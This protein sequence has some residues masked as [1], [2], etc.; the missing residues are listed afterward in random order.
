MLGVTHSKLA[1]G[2]ENEHGRNAP[3]GS[4]KASAQVDRA[5][6]MPGRPLD[7]TT[8]G[9][10]ETSFGYDFSNVRIHDDADAAVTAAGVNAAAFTFGQDV[11]F[12]AGRYAPSTG[13]GRELL[14]HELAHTIQQRDA[15]TEGTDV[16][17]GSTLEQ[18]AAQAGRA[19]ALGAPVTHS[20]GSSSLAVARQ[21]AEDDLDWVPDE[22]T[23]DER[24]E[25]L[26]YQDYNRS[27]PNSKSKIADERFAQ[28]VGYARRR[29][30]S[31][32]ASRAAAEARSGQVEIPS[33]TDEDDEAEIAPTPMALPEPPAGKRPT[34]PPPARVR[35]RRRGEPAAQARF[36]PGGFTDEEAE[37]VDQESREALWHAEQEQKRAEAE[38][39]RE[40]DESGPDPIVDGYVQT[41]MGT[42]EHVRMR[43]SELQA[44]QDR[45]W[46]RPILEQ[47]NNIANAGPV[48]TAG[49]VVGGTARVLRGGESRDAVP[50]A[51]ALGGVGDAF[52]LGVGA[53]P[54]QGTA[55]D[56]GRAPGAIVG[57]APLRESIPEPQ[58]LGQTSTAPE[59]AATTVETAPASVAGQT[60]PSTASTPDPAP[61]SV[62]GQTRPSTASTPDPAPA[63]VA[64]QTRPSTAST[65]DPAPA[66]VAGQTRPS[67]APTPDPAP[68]A[69]QP[70][71]PRVVAATRQLAN[72]QNAA[73]SASG[74][75]QRA[76][77]KAAEAEHAHQ[78][79]EMELAKARTDVSAAQV[80]RDSASEAYRNAKPGSRQEPRKAFTQAKN[81][82]EKLE[83]KLNQAERKVTTA[84]EALNDATAAVKRQ[85]T[86]SA[87]LKMKAERAQ[88]RLAAT[89]RA[90]A[91]GTP[92][93]LKPGDAFSPSKRRPNFIP[94]GP[95]G[96]VTRGAAGELEH[97][98]EV[99]V[100]KDPFK[101][102]AQQADLQRILKL[103]KTNPQQAGNEFAKLT[104]QI[105]R[106]GDIAESYRAVH[107]TIGRR[108]DFGNIKELTIE[109]R[110]GALGDSKL[111]QLWFDLN[112]HG[113]IDLTVPMLSSAAEDQ[114]ARLAGEWQK[115]T[116]RKPLILVRETAR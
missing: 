29:L 24:E 41:D 60:R 65:P 58:Q 104:G 89:E 94:N 85:A 39:A 16:G 73:D 68:A 64:G 15:S 44:A 106:W 91:Q 108:W 25:F 96:S 5:L 100:F 95:R 35:P 49:L 13:E 6:T 69:P 8:R 116:G 2:E 71:D 28:L 50:S 54:L 53:P 88:A 79:A 103:A 55:A 27:F 67:T 7:P 63:P 90:V 47:M 4:G 57:E 34:R 72:A 105:E 30:Q 3:L 17:P 74:R 22:L 87:E 82:L 101:T 10:M 110:A 21:P 20:L 52:S 14:A 78:L 99:R 40:L 18:S 80:A 33:S 42:S 66:P 109:G 37:R 9:R 11:V 19:A 43:R 62:A 97:G 32:E 93:R 77:T 56:P 83:S 36:L 113:S 38:K 84:E 114:L 23:T 92:D 31:R 1:H 112:E 48:S 98:A 76:T 61:A 45:A 75:L 81:A 102:A 59:P 26:R 107:G 70:I 111:D 51:L 46:N 115:W 12:G 86:S